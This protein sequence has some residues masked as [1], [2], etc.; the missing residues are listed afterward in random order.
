MKINAKDC[1]NLILERVPEFKD[2]WDRFQKDWKDEEVK[3]GLCGQVSEF[4]HFVADN[5]K[6]LGP[7]RM[8]EIFSLAEEI[9]Q[10]GD[11]DSQ[12]A[13]TTC[14]LENIL[15]RCSYRLIPPEAFIPFL[16][17]ESR[18]FSRSWDE[19]SEDRTPGLWEDH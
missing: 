17:P 5:H 10:M 3:P 4:S 9:L 6:Q 13:I 19:L 7:Q 12:T 16:G 11:N 18:A 15:N 2:D 1:I 14:F 8:R